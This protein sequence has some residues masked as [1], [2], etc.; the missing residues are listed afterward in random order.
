MLGWSAVIPPYLENGH[1]HQPTEPPPSHTAIV[2][3]PSP[4]LE[5]SG[6]ANQGHPGRLGDLL[7]GERSPEEAVRRPNLLDKLAPSRPPLGSKPSGPRLVLHNIRPGL[8]SQCSHVDFRRRGVNAKHAKDLSDPFS[9]KAIEGADF[10]QAQP[11]VSKLGHCLGS[12][13][14]T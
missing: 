5:S 6:D 4:A 1:S 14:V 8:P 10:H 3:A 7:G 9:G 12:S 2:R 11:L 13:W